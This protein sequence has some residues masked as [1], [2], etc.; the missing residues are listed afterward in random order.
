MIEGN[1]IVVLRAVGQGVSFRFALYPCIDLI[2]VDLLG[3]I[4]TRVH[5]KSTGI[6]ALSVKCIL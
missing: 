4:K 5:G 6:K 3:Q 1:R 2:P